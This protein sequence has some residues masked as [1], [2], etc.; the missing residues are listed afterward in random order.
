M[1]PL[2]IFY[3]LFV[4]IFLQF[5]W[6]TYLLF[7]L[8]KEVSQ[9]K[10]EQ[11]DMIASDSTE[12]D[13]NKEI[14]KK[15]LIQR[16]AMIVGEGL[17]FITLIGIGMIKTKHAIQKEID[18]AAQQ[19]NFLLSVTHE[20]KSPLA[21]V[22][23]NLET[24]QKRSL[25]DNTR[26]K[27]IEHAISETQRLNDLVENILLAAMM[28][29]RSFVYHFEPTN[30][31]ALVYDFARKQQSHYHSKAIIQSEI[32]PDINWPVDRTAMRS[33]L[34]NLVENAVK[35]SSGIAEINI[36]L[37]RNQDKVILL[38]ADH[39]IGIQEEEKEKIFEKF[40][41]IGHEDTRKSK[42]TGLGLFIVK[43]VS[44]KHNGKLTV[45]QNLPAGSIFEISLTAS[46]LLHS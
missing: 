24:L 31:S 23:L 37:K 12:A 13:K 19:K 33:A 5:F 45:R 46:S 42:G 6:W 10:S 32:E 25:E 15:K 1:K 36:Q 9:L 7:D 41:R 38:V 43:N 14:L 11:F 44:E 40:Y 39:G 34:Q 27:L 20:L 16:R 22:Q 3:I 29:N 18:L 4:Y 26:V 8:N 28:E 2:L 35:Y 17:V 21:S 30:L